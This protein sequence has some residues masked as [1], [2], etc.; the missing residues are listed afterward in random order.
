M[1]TQLTHFILHYLLFILIPAYPCK[2]FRTLKHFPNIR[3]KQPL[4]WILRRSVIISF[5][6]TFAELRSG[7]SGYIFYVGEELTETDVKAKFE[8]GVLKLSLPKK[9]A[10][11][12]PEAKTIAIEG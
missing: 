6:D 10:E 12:I 4:Q 11:K 8:D 3:I 9:E 1:V 2:A 7:K 5:V